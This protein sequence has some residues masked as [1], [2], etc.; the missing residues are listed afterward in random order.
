MSR[1][2]TRVTDDT[3]LEYGFDRVPTPGYFYSVERDGDVIE[4]GD[5][6]G[7]MLTHPN[8]EQ[9]NRSEIVEKLKEYGAREDHIEAMAMDR[10]L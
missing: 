6:R 5:T 10:P 7:F 8:E 3:I 2:S 9:M 1:H 4:A